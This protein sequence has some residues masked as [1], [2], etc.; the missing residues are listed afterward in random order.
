[1]PAQHPGRCN[2]K[3]IDPDK[4]RRK[5]KPCR[6]FNLYAEA[7]LCRRCTGNGKTCVLRRKQSAALRRGKFHRRI[8]FRA[9]KVA[10]M[11]SVFHNA[12]HA[13]RPA[14]RMRCFHAA[15]KLP[16]SG[17][18]R[19][20][21][22]RWFAHPCE[23]AE[24]AEALHLFTKKVVP[25]QLLVRTRRKQV[26]DILNAD[27]A[28]LRTRIPAGN[29][30]ITAGSA[31]LRAIDVAFAALIKHDM[32]VSASFKDD[33]I[34]RAEQFPY[35]FRHACAFFLRFPV[36]KLIIKHARFHHVNHFPAEIRFK[37]IAKG[38]VICRPH[39]GGAIQE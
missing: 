30:I 26:R 1:M 13:H 4:G 23:R 32:A 27:A 14:A 24:D 25:P 39:K 8:R 2:L 11:H 38:I 15:R 20:H 22:F 6:F 16:T 18:T 19:A 37:R 33:D 29:I 28:V 5:P 17:K 34:A 31:C 21:V 36:G 3:P 35:Y 10:H 7:G 12:A 9:A